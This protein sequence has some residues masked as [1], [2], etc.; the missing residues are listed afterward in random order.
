MA[1]L[2]LH[3]FTCIA[4]PCPHLHKT[5]MKSLRYGNALLK[6]RLSSAGCDGLYSICVR[7]K[8]T[9]AM[10]TNYSP[11]K[12]VKDWENSTYSAKPY[13]ESK[14]MSSTNTNYR[15]RRVLALRSI[16]QW[17]NDKNSGKDWHKMWTSPQTFQSNKVPLD[18]R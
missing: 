8:L 16:M 3:I 18:L 15:T 6:K 7:F 14:K 13:D 9:A 12:A 5:V 17:L 11:E 2:L 1:V 4:E 10:E